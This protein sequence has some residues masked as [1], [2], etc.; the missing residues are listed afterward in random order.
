MKEADRLVKLQELRGDRQSGEIMYSE[1]Q[2]EKKKKKKMGWLCKSLTD[3]QT[4]GQ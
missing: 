4:G 1:R 3:K 2:K